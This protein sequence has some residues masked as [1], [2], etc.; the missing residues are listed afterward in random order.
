MP[1]VATP[2]TVGTT[3]NMIRSV[4]APLTKVPMPFW[5]VP[6]NEMAVDAVDMLGV[7]LNCAPPLW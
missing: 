1:P 3:L 5:L 4:L 6:V 2:D 7:T